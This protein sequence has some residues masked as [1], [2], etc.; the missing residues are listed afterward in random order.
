MA[1][2]KTYTTAYRNATVFRDANGNGVLDEPAETALLTDADGA[3]S[4]P[5]GKGRFLLSGGVD[6]ATGQTN[7]YALLSAPKAARSVSPLTSVWQALLDRGANQNKIKK[8]IGA[9]LTFSL[10]KYNAQPIGGNADANQEQG[11]RKEGQVGL[12]TQWVSRIADTTFGARFA[13][14]GLTGEALKAAV[15]AAE[16][17]VI[18]DF[19]Q[20]LL[21]SGQKQL[22][23]SDRDTVRALLDTTLERSGIE[24]SD[25]ELD[26]SSQAASEINGQYDA[27]PTDKLDEL[28]KIAD[29]S[30]DVFAARDF[31]TLIQQYTGANLNDQVQ[32]GDIFIPAPAGVAFADDTG[33]SPTDG[34]TRDNTPTFSGKVD[35]LAEEVHVYR[36][37]VMVF[38]V[39]A[40]NGAWTYVSPALPD[41]SYAFAFAG[42]NSFGREGAPTPAA[43]LTVDTLAPAV[44]TVTPSLGTNQN[45]TVRGTWKAAAGDALSV[46]VAGQTYVEGNGLTVSANQTWS[47]KLAG[48]LPPGV[49]DVIAQASDAA[50]NLAADTGVGELVVQSVASG[51]KLSSDAPAGTAVREGGTVTFSVAPAGGALT[52]G[53]TLTLTLGGGG[54]QAT[55]ADFSPSAQTFGFAAGDSSA[56]TVTVT[57]VKDGQKEGVESYVASLLDASGKT[58]DTLSGTID[59]PA[60]APPAVSGVSDIAGASGIVLAL[61]N[62]SFSD[63]DNDTLKVSLTATGGELGGLADADPA[64]AGI[65]LIGTPSAVTTAFAAATFKGTAAG[66]G[67]VAISVSDGVNAPVSAKIGVSLTNASIFK[68]A[69]PASAAESASAVYTVTRAG[70]AS[71][72]ALVD[73]VVTPG[74]GASKADY[75]TPTV[76]G[77]QGSNIG[78]VGGTL[79]F[80]AGATQAT[81]SVPILPDNALETGETLT[82]GL[83]A[84]VADKSGS[85]IDASQNS[86]TTALLDAQGRF[87]L[88]TSASGNAATQEGDNLIFTV[89][90]NGA[91]NADTTLTLTLEGAVVGS[92]STL[93][94]A[95]DFSPVSQKISFKAGDTV[96][97][98]VVVSVVDDGLAEGLEGYRANLLDS[99]SN[100]LASTLGLIAD[101]Q[102]SRPVIVGVADVSGISEA[103]IPLPDLKFLDADNDTLTVTLTAS[104][105]T[106]GN[107]TDAAPSTPGVQLIGSP[108]AV[109]ASFANATFFASANS[110]N[111]AVSVSDGV[112]SPVTANIGVTIDG[113]NPSVFEL[114]GSTTALEGTQAAYTVARVGDASKP[115]LV[116][117]ALL[118]G[119]GASQSDYTGLTVAGAS[120]TNFTG[121]SGT[122]VFAAGSSQATISLIVVSDGIVETGETL[123]ATL[124]PNASDTSGATVSASKN[125]LTVALLDPQ[126][127][128]T[129]FSLTS[130]APVGSPSLEGDILTF[131]IAPAGAVSADTTL[132]LNLTGASVGSVSTLASPADFSPA[133]PTVFFVAGDV[134]PK[135]VS[136]NVVNDGSTEGLEGYKAALLNGSTELTSL[137]GIVSDSFDTVPPTL[138]SASYDP[139]GNSISLVFDES[140]DSGSIPQP[141]DFSLVDGG[142]LS[143]GVFPSSISGSA[144][145]LSVSGQTPAASL[146]LSYSPSASGPLQDLAGNDVAAFSVQIPTGAQTNVPPSISGASDVSGFKG[147]Q[148][149]LPDLIFTDP[150]SNLTVTVESTSSGAN[151]GGI[152]DADSLRPG[153]Q[154]IGTPAAITR[155]FT[156][157]TIFESDSA[158]DAEDVIVTADDGINAVVTSLVHVT[159]NTLILL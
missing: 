115:A 156:G 118:P 42:V 99:A 50:G 157:A 72:A 117:F 28:T 51:F 15:Q 30:A 137:V 149:A 113:A 122:L 130:D 120:V 77:A 43:S 56:K 85:L 155:A 94:A 134:G 146:S 33:V 110:G 96:P 40:L 65:Q 108:A 62:L 29:N 79:S 98:S 76:S 23:L 119:G 138:V 151:F 66:T 141:S 78:A 41:G 58:I 37:G 93:A 3:F 89:T 54:G 59:D 136:V 38:S 82:V 95:T 6:I 87:A 67:N 60:N 125:S 97:R 34:L 46:T 123:T 106:L 2:I 25:T 142:G 144:A 48:T 49:Y 103:P 61:P 4:A 150:D 31:D 152:A 80:S 45:P 35:I 140:L 104:G 5:G 10:N 132:T 53:A 153:V 74:G 116:D 100:S 147:A 64:T 21:T 39:P 17:K 83:T 44:P 9:P 148:L 145:I 13:A 1:K 91:V 24:L 47:V 158:V 84:N 12:L 133:S 18:G 57:I 114:S 109:T 70:D 11:T 126:P 69:G 159:W 63:A 128:Q 8:L 154:L 135:T 73:F 143:F 127:T 26:R 22:D 68:I 124:T 75:G 92:V 20:A 81:I 7:P 55:A 86:A 112:N 102:N 101:A 52:A 105:G 32:T 16:D 139:K 131:T 129:Q 88:A 111:V 14:L 121:K 71:K 19:A 36:N 107:L 27:A 90:P